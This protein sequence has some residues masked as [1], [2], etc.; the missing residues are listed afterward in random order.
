VG[1]YADLGAA[2]NKTAGVLVGESVTVAASFTVRSLG[3]VAGPAGGSLVSIGLYTDVGNA[4]S[5]LLASAQNK[6]VLPGRNEYAVTPLQLGMGNYWI[7]AVYDTVTPLEAA[8]AGG[9]TV[10]RQSLTTGW[11]SP[12]PTTLTGTTPQS[13]AAT[14][15]YILIT[16]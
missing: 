13:G 14:N 1:Y 4:P 9:T 2:S 5:Q 16:Q 8:M 6:A 7:M 11:G 3:L 15:Y 10:T 12:L